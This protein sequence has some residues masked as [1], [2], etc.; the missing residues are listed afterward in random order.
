MTNTVSDIGE[1]R[2]IDE[3]LLPGVSGG[4]K[5]DDCAFLSVGEQE[6][7][8][9]MD[10]CPTPVAAMLNCCTPEVWG[11][12]TA[13]INL[14]DIAACGG[15]PLGMLVS[16]EMPDDTELSFINGFQS[17]LLRALQRSGAKLLGGNVKSASRFNATGTAIGIVGDRHVTRHINSDDARLY[18]VG[19]CGNFWAA[20]V[21]QYANWLGDEED[22][23][24]QLLPALLD[25]APQTSAGKVIGSL[26][27]EIACM[28]CSDGVGSAVQQLAN[29]NSMD[30]VLEE[31]PQ[32]AIKPS[33][34]TTLEHHGY[35]IENACYQFGDWQLACLVAASDAAK[36]EKAMLDTP[37]TL[38]GRGRSGARNVER[39]D[40]KK[41]AAQVMNK[42]FAGGYNS[43][44]SIE[45]LLDWFMERSVFV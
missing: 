3:I 11:H 38:L 36:F 26:P 41:L 18:I 15:T 23:R 34:K 21:G 14:S 22:T 43:I 33:A 30:I 17:G 27:F 9:S 35:R 37:L 6:L 1:I 31:A 7:L 42:N 2:L 39:A 10:P 28:D 44:S 5:G 40:G 13:I 8:W 45:A 25:P 19:E 29:A 12:Y 16:L 4:S 24:S 20:V 32:W